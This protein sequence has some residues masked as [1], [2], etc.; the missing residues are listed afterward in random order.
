MASARRFGEKVRWTLRQP[1]ELIGGAQLVRWT[2]IDERHRPTG[3]CRQ[4]V[5]GTLQGP[6]AGLA[7][8]QYEGEES[9]YLFG[10][11]ANWNTVTDTWHETLEQAPQ[12]AEFEYEGVA[13]TW[14]TV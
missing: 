12:Q 1:P 6:A 5:G 4:I 8:C 9:Y 11:D 13:A 14:N 7:I 3:D 2:V 10:C